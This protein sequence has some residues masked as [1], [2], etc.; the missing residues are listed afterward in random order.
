MR[1][2]ESLYGV[3]R[4][5]ENGMLLGELNQLVGLPG[6][7]KSCLPHGVFEDEKPLSTTWQRHLQSS[8]KERG[9][10][11]AVL[12]NGCIYIDPDVSSE[13]K[14]KVNFGL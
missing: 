9:S 4:A 7:E 14:K 12:S 13:L 10:G 3:K 1:L 2:S 11:G 8:R 6:A 5:G